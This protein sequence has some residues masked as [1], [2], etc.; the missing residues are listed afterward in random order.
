MPDDRYRQ[1]AADYLQA[2]EDKKTVLVVSPRPT[3]KRPRSRRR[4][5]PSFARPASS[6]RRSASLP[7]W[8]RPTSAKRS[9]GWRPRTGRAT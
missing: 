4:S 7:G 8:S 5:A 3:P 6:G 9:G 2:L 1:I